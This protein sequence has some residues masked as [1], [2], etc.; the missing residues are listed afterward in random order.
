[1]AKKEK[2]SETVV[3]VV[4][5]GK[6]SKRSIERGYFEKLLRMGCKQTQ[7]CAF[8]NVTV[9]ELHG[10]IKRTYG[11][12]TDFAHM[13]DMFG[14]ELYISNKQSLIRLAEYDTKACIYLNDL[15]EAKYGDDDVSQD[16]QLAKALQQTAKR[17]KADQREVEKYHDAIRAEQ[18]DEDDD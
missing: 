12:Q 15:L 6:Q 18:E 4:S 9:K 8:F 14:M 5:D 13:R 7:V 17:L 10:W 16:N 1:M 2:P 11:K 3:P